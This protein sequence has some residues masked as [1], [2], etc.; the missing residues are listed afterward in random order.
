MTMQGIIGCVLMFIVNSF[1]KLPLQG[2][3]LL[4]I[5]LQGNRGEVPYLQLQS[6]LRG[7]NWPWLDL[8]GGVLVLEF[9]VHNFRTSQDRVSLKTKNISLWATP[10][11]TP[12]LMNEEFKTLK[13]LNLSEST[14]VFYFDVNITFEQVL[15]KL[16]KCFILIKMSIL[17]QF[18]IVKAQ[19]NNKTCGAALSQFWS[20]ESSIGCFWLLICMISGVAWFQATILNFRLQKVYLL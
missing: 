18:S 4:K 17:S 15:G 3:C 11:N 9:E 12:C 14:T 2:V 8:S 7:E 19:N 13:T 20:P 10:P 16:W 5:K 1:L 6:P